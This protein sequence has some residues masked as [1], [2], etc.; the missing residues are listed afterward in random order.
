MN[1]YA[2]YEIESDQFMHA[3]A[4]ELDKSFEFLKSNGYVVIENVISKSECDQI[5][6]EANGGKT[7]LRRRQ[8]SPQRNLD[9][10]QSVA[11][12]EAGNVPRGLGP[13][14]AFRRPSRE[15]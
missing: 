8:K 10:I 2:K 12:N 15:S 11:P 14:P 13:H 6:D 3:M 7:R 1:L 4:K 9:R 5:I